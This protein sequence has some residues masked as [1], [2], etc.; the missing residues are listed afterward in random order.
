MAEDPTLAADPSPLA[1]KAWWSGRRD[2]Y[3]IALLVAGL[4]AFICYAAAVER[5]IDLHAPGDWE[6]TIFT[7]VFQ[8]F[9]YLIMVGLANVCYFLGP[10]S[11][12]VLKPH[13]VATYRTTAFR[14]GFW[15]SVLLP[16]TP[17]TVLFV[18]CSI[19][20]A[21]DKRIILELI[22]RVILGQLA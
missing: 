17:A 8:G 2:R 15:F 14:L 9:A 5:C 3:N 21:E 1:R 4:L 13:N 12:R 20:R 18:S 19:H 11:E 16:F 10:W 22:R 7:T 6:I